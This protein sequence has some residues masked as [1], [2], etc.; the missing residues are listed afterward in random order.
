MTARLI[1]DNDQIHAVTTQDVEPVL[2]ANAAERNNPQPR[3]RR[4]ECG[5][6]VATIPNVIILK[7]LYEEYRRGNT[8]LRYPSAAFNEIIWCKLQDPDWKY[9][10]TDK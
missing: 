6:K 5:N 3:N 4:E 1:L 10:R 7:W 8:K 9:L 2:E